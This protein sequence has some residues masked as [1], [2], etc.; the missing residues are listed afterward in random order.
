MAEETW[1]RRIRAPIPGEDLSDLDASTLGRAS[2]RRTLGTS[3]TGPDACFARW[4][5][6]RPELAGELQLRV[7]AS[8]SGTDVAVLSSSLDEPGLLRC[9]VDEVRGMPFEVDTTTVEVVHRYRFGGGEVPRS[10]GRCSDASRQGLEIRRALWRERLAANTGAG[11]V[12]VWRLAESQCELGSWSARRA[13]LSLMLRSVRRVRDRIAVYRA[14]G[15]AGSRAY[16]RRSMLR[17]ARSPGD[18]LAL[19]RALGV[20]IDVDWRVFR[21]GWARAATPAAKLRLVRRW[22]AVFPDELDLR[23]RE[24]RLLE[25]TE[26]FEQAMRRAGELRRHPLADARVVGAL[27]EF[28]L[29]RDNPDRARRVFSE[30]VERAPRDPWA[31]RRL[32]DLYRAH[33][34]F[35]AAYREYGTLAQLVPDDASVLLLLARAAVGAGRWDEALRLQQRVAGVEGIGKLEGA[36]GAARLWLL[37]TL[38][39]L[40]G[41]DG[42][43]PD[44][45][46]ARWRRS[47]AYRGTPAVIGVLTWEHP[48]DQPAFSVLPPSAQ[49][50]DAS[51]SGTPGANARWEAAELREGPLGIAGQVFP[52]AEEGTVYFRVGALEDH[53]G[54]RGSARLRVLLNLGAE[55][56]LVR[57]IDFELGEEVV[58]ALNEEGELRRL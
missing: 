14:L 4:R 21:A 26:D 45:L 16:W 55:G 8:S 51:A 18:L 46:R 5:V 34:W 28:W 11:A 56:E 38:A 47:G 53:G 22:L 7:R 3:R 37:E 44:A 9:V 24:L 40:Q 12:A 29:R 36:A 49:D 32:G 1:V 20:G 23:I 17:D 41:R 48:E 35:D 27:G 43:P 13:L 57:H 58:F 10:P 25:A 6:R 33:G 50:T 30:L 19:H 52:D 39:G 31:R 2:L 15:H 42:V 54:E